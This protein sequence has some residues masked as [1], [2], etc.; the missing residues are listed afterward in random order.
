[1]EGMR[2]TLFS[3]FGKKQSD[4][5]K[6]LAGVFNNVLL[7]RRNNFLSKIS[8]EKN[9]RSM[10]KK[11]DPSEKFLFGDKIEQV[12]KNLRNSNQLNP[13]K[14]DRFSFRGRGYGSYRGQAHGFRSRDGGLPWRL[15][16]KPRWPW[17]C[18]Q[19]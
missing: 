8:I 2:R 16:W 6:V 18:W 12:A 3:S 5:M 10:V 19:R 9:A 7:M 4:V 17:K 13:L 11:L 1:M 15:P 14:P